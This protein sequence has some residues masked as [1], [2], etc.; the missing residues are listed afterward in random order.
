MNSKL[1][2]SVFS[3]AGIFVA[4]TGCIHLKQWK[5]SGKVGP[6]H[7][8]PPAVV[9]SQWNE[10][11]SPFVISA[12]HCTDADGWWHVFA[13]PEIDQLVA[14]ANRDNLP[15]KAAL[16]RVQEQAYLRS[17]AVGELFPRAQGFG[18]YQRNQFSQNGN[19]FGVPGFGNSFD[20]YQMGFNA[21]WEL[22]VWGKL[23]RRVESADAQFQASREDEY[24]VRLTLTADVVATYVEIRV[25]QR[26]IQIAHDQ[27]EA[28]SETLRLA[29]SRFENGATSKLDVSQAKVLVET[30][31]ALIPQLEN[32]LI[33]ANNRLCLL[34]GTTPNQHYVNAAGQIPQPPGEVVVGV[35]LD[36]I[37]RR[38]DIRRAERDVASQSALVGVAA[39]ELFPKFALRGT[40]NWQAF[41]FNS[42]FES[43]SNGGAVIPG[44]QWDLLNFGRLKNNVKV[45]E[46]RLEEAI[47]GY[48]QAV[49]NANSEAES[50][51]SSYVKKKEETAALRL[52]VKATEESLTVARKQYKEGNTDLDRVNNLRKELIQQLD[53]LTLAEGQV[54]IALIR[55]YKT[56]GGGWTI[57]EACHIVE[58]SSPMGGAQNSVPGQILLDNNIGPNPELTSFATTPKYSAPTAMKQPTMAAPSRN[59]RPPV[60]SAP[61]RYPLFDQSNSDSFDHGS[62]TFVPPTELPMPSASRSPAPGRTRAGMRRTSTQPIR[63]AE[64]PPM[65]S[66]R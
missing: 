39:A 9:N 13:D 43:A 36:L 17:I 24:D 19:L 63:F 21:S 33:Q 62:G 18:E 6:D 56:M 12:D 48:Q 5:Q 45:Q 32:E 51:L 22:D 37:R 55:I 47:V 28:Q 35:P 64:L 29:E 66:K 59:Q 7:G 46:T 52:A 53:N 57:P 16:L 54:L 20:L 42:L 58:T 38:P 11:N 2:I 30:T 44:F 65:G 8:A 40:V 4:L 15:L 25:L 61:S 50:A 60:S 49:L 10:L 26:R 23:R 3:A 1:L 31:R 14:L 41:D 34:L 27:V